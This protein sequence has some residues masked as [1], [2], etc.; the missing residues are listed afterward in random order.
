MI[1]FSLAGGCFICSEK[2]NTTLSDA[3]IVWLIDN[4]MKNS[5]LAAPRTKFSPEEDNILIDLVEAIDPVDWKLVADAMG[6]RTA[7]QCRERY[8]N[9]LAPNVAVKEWTKEEDEK[10]LTQY[11]IQG[12]RWALIRAVFPGRS[13]VN[14]KNRWA[15]LKHRRAPPAET[16]AEK[17]QGEEDYDLG[18]LEDLFV[19]NQ[20][21]FSEFVEN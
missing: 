14:I 2:V 5:V 11:K 1:T 17:Q 8:H 12:P 16:E 6:N 18:I 19:D 3:K 7:R 13:C 10:L 4:Q 20:P 9:Y 15:K 21:D